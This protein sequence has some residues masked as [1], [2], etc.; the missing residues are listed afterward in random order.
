MKLPLTLIP[1]GT[2]LDFIGKRYIAFAFSAMVTVLTIFF[3]FTKGLNLGID[4]TG[5]IIMEVRSKQEINV[6]EV[7]EL[8]AKNEYSGT[9]IQ[10]FGSLNDVMIRFRAVEN[11]SQAKEVNKIK[12]LLTSKLGKDIEFRKVDYV[13]PRVGKELIEN[14]VLALFFSLIVMLLYIWYR[15]DWQY[16]IGAII[17]LFHDAIAVMGFYSFSQY[18][19]DLTS[20]AALLTVIGYSINDTVVIYD[21]IRENVR[22]HKVTDI[23]AIINLSVNE[24][25]SR[26]TMTSLTTLVVCF[27]LAAFGGEVIEGFSTATLFGIAF[28]TYSSIYIS[29]PVLIYTGIGSAKSTSKKHTE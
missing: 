13:G 3:L 4:F 20:V 22:K 9:S 5:G 7:R 18:E 19:F 11:D 25:L 1:V 28:G 21:R 2:K 6:G 17:A 15:F 10:N 27:A 23:A 8:L 14:A 12:E 16:G 29:A 26:T 24:T